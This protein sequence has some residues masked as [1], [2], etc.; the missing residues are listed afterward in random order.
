M[1]VATQVVVKV[2]VVTQVAYRPINVFLFLLAQSFFR[3]DNA[4]LRVCDFA[5]RRETRPRHERGAARASLRAG[6]AGGAPW[7]SVVVGRAIL[8]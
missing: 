3:G 7:G 6:R 8:A 2:M 5:R 4:R 1:T